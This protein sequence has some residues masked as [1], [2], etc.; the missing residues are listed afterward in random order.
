MKRAERAFFKDFDKRLESVKYEC[1]LNILAQGGIYENLG[2]KEE[3]SLMDYIASLQK[4]M[5]LDDAL[6]CELK[7]RV[8]KLAD[9]L[10]WLADK[11]LPAIKRFVT[12]YER[13]NALKV[14]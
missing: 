14:A 4:C 12:N 1:F 6:W 13:K 5:D 11:D 2:K 9:E 7:S 3:L 10:E 8:R